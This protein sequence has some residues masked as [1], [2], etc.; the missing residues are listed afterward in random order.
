M[1][2]LTNHSHL[3]Y[4]FASYGKNIKSIIFNSTFILCIKKQMN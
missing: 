4:E 2:L 1:K 3:L